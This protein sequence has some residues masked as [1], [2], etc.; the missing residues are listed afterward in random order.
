MAI[1]PDRPGTHTHLRH[2]AGWIACVHGAKVSLKD[3]ESS[4]AVVVI[5]PLRSIPTR[6]AE[7]SGSAS[8]PARRA[9]RKPEQAQGCLIGVGARRL[10]WFALLGGGIAASEDPRSTR[11]A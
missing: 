5:S 11:D 4:G 6:A 9:W 3:G 8:R 10:R 1:I 2:G 7:E